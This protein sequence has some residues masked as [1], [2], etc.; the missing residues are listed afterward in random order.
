MKSST[1]LILG[2][3]ALIAYLYITNLS[4]KISWMV[5][6]ISLNIQGALT[7]QLDV[8]FLVTNAST[9]TFTITGMLVNCI[10]NGSNIGT[11]IINAT[12][13]PGQQSVGVTINLSDISIITDVANAA[14]NGV[15]SISITFTGSGKI[16]NA[17]ISFSQN[18]T[19]AV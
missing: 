18:Y 16:N 10:Y 13:L 7:S 12:I 19:Y 5:Q 1:W 6:N 11:G 15:S 9:T 8:T 4:N 2:G 3:V 17:P 14:M